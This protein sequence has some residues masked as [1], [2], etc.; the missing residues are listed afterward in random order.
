MSPS[1]NKPVS[2]TAKVRFEH[3]DKTFNRGSVNEVVLL[4]DFSLSVREGEFVSVVGS[5]GSGK[6]TL[7]NLLCGTLF[8][9]EGR[10]YLGELDLTGLKDYE[11]AAWI[12]RVFQDPA[13]GTCPSLTI[14]E[15]MSLADNKG[16]SYGLGSG[17]NRRRADFYRSQLELLHLGLEDKLHL[18][19]G[20]LSGGQRQALALLISTLT[21]IELL[22]LDEHTAALDPKASDT[23][24]ELTE[25]VVR[26]KGITTIMVTHNLR[27]AASY[28][29]R[30]LMMHQGRC[31]LD[32]AE[33]EKRQYTIT[34]LLKIFN[35]ISV[36]CGN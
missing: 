2:V 25:K 32:A 36:E 33:D 23:V 26:E 22:V 3:I 8:P 10:I 1:D 17:I 35:E 18:P 12:G 29:N 7:L 6:T 9:D 13:R 30:I 31:V 19:V 4:E 34:D 21:P 20:A 28:G 16:K 11:R 15:N 27:F 14:L 5:N 24:M